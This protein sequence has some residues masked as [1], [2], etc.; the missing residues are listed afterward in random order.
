[1]VLKMNKILITVCG[2]VFLIDIITYFI[3]YQINYIFTTSYTLLFVCFTNISLLMFNNMH[4]VT[5]KR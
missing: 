2:L 1:M 5:N 3:P 4:I